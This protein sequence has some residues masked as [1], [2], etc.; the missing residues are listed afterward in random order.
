M[1]ED[2]RTVTTQRTSKALK[3]QLVLATWL[4]WLGILPIFFFGTLYLWAIVIGGVWYMI[5][6]V[7]IWWHHE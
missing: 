6:S 1:M 4:F 7:L 5:I 3:V 2:N